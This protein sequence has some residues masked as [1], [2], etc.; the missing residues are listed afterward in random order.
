[1]AVHNQLKRITPVHQP[2]SIIYSDNN[3]YISDWLDN[4]PVITSLKQQ[5]EFI[6]TVQTAPEP[7]TQSVLTQ[8]VVDT[9]G[10]QPRNG[11][12]V[13]IEDVAELW[14]FNGTEW[15]YFS[16]T[17]LKD[18]TTTSKGVVQIG[19]GLN[20][21]SGIISL[22][23][24]S[25][26]VNRTTVTITDTVV[27]LSTQKNTDYVC[28]NAITSLTISQI[29]TSFYHT[30]ITF[31]TGSS[32]SFSSST[33]IN[34]YDH[35]NPPTFAINTSYR[36]V[37]SNG[38]G[39]VYVLNTDLYLT[40]SEASSTYLPLSGGTLRGDLTVQNLAGSRQVVIDSSSDATLQL[41]GSSTS[42]PINLKSDGSS[43]KIYS[44]TSTVDNAFKLN[45]TTGELYAVKSGTDYKLLNAQ[46]KGAANGVA[47]LDSNSKLN[48]SE[49]PYATSSTV[50]GI[51]QSYDSS[52]GTWTIIT[53]D[54]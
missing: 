48:P 50:G 31:T 18:A 13:A 3:G 51:K 47:E 1:M 35:S 40:K 5:T 42:N 39:F 44:N 21:N 32:F 2:N 36:I 26:T 43:F 8:F 10:R 4:D 49:I 38:I 54:L 34:W 37:I 7:D 52:T 45:P 11:D 14:L 12:E 29:E 9:A 27:T 6:G 33:L 25:V 28:S 24:N 16:N 41:K 23:N 17:E 19:T 46:D 20:V 22:D 30:T 15:I 53:E